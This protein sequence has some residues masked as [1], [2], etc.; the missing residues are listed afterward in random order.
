MRRPLIFSLLLAVTL[1]ACD[2]DSPTNPT[3][4]EGPV[5]W[6]ELLSRA[7]S[8]LEAQTRQ[9]VRT[10]AA[11]Q[12]AWDEILEDTPMPDPLPLVD[13]ETDMVLVVGSGEQ[14]TECHEIAITDAVSD[15]T[16]ITVT[17]TETGPTTVC[18]CDDLDASPVEVVRLPRADVVTFV[19]INVEVCND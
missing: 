3:L 9:V 4:P 6:T 14:T 7:Q 1:P 11:F 5:T 13:F 12:T 18:V 19:N 16:D 8:S 17:V 10:P 15:G 2:G